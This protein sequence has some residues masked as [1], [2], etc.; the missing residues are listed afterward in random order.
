MH[1]SGCCAKLRKPYDKKGYKIL[2]SIILWFD[3]QI[4]SWHKSLGKF[5][6]RWNSFLSWRSEISIAN[7]H[8]WHRKVNYIEQGEPNNMTKLTRPPIDCQFV[9]C[10]SG[11]TRVSGLKKVQNW[12]NK[13]CDLSSSKN[14]WPQ[15]SSEGGKIISKTSVRKFLNWALGFYP[16]NNKAKS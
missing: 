16:T 8:S 3:I 2:L 13:F 12:P 11:T 1:A 14:F 7:Q 6:R 15:L 9:A 4:T 10:L 5:T